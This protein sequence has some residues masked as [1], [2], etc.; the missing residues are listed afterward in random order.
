MP[1]NAARTAIP[2]N[3][4]TGPETDLAPKIDTLIIATS[5]VGYG[6]GLTG[7]AIMVDV[8]TPGRDGHR[9]GVT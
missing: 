3:T 6:I 5:V 2:A 4:L 7:F 1:A 8:V 9:R